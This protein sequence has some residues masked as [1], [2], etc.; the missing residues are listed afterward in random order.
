MTKIASLRTWR[1]RIN[2]IMKANRDKMGGVDKAQ[3]M[4]DL[5][6]GIINGI[7]A[8]CN[9]TMGLINSGW[10]AGQLAEMDRPMV[11]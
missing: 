5:R 7:G 1:G 9:N 4:R 6:A 2:N 3:R 8:G 10:P 11:G